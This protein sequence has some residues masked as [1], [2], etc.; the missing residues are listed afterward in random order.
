MI[1]IPCNQMLDKRFVVKDNSVR[2]FCRYEKLPCFCAHGSYGFVLKDRDFSISCFKNLYHEVHEVSQRNTKKTEF[3]TKTS[4]RVSIVWVYLFEFSCQDHAPSCLPQ[5]RLSR[6][7]SFQVSLR[8]IW[9][10]W[11]LGRRGLVCRLARFIHDFDTTYILLDAY[12]IRE[13]MYTPLNTW[14]GALLS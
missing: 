3:E 11:P 4:T 12:I 5:I 9:G 13:C 1:T 8:R 14:L 7:L 6:S 10:R 2:Y